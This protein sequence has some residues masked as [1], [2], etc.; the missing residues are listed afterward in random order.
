M[1]F[2][3]SFLVA[4]VSA[5]YVVMELLQPKKKKKKKNPVHSLGVFRFLV[6]GDFHGKELSQRLLGLGC[7]EV[8]EDKG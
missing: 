1:S 3:C 8:S 2:N 6:S 5:G 7:G 4:P